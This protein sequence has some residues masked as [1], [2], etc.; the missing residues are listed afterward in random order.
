MSSFIK[1]DKKSFSFLEKRALL[2]Y[3]TFEDRVEFLKSLMP[4]K[5]FGVISSKHLDKYAYLLEDDDFFISFY[6]S[7]TLRLALFHSDYRI[8]DLELESF[9]KLEKLFKPYSK[10]VRSKSIDGVNYFLKLIANDDVHAAYIKGRSLSREQYKDVS[11][12][13]FW[14]VLIKSHHEEYSTEIS[15]RDLYIFKYSYMSDLWT[16]F[17]APLF[18]YFVAVWSVYTPFEI[19]KKVAGFIRDNPKYVTMN[20]IYLLTDYYLQESSFDDVVPLE[21]IIDMYGFTTVAESI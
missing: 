16:I 14:A 11:L 1:V 4:R 10:R 12:D 8:N 13:Y 9:L 5:Y 2:K 17:Y 21:W 7:K 15:C 6:R 3:S 18:T 19:Q 20:S